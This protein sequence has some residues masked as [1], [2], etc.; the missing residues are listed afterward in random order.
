MRY[1]I[2]TLSTKRYSIILKAIQHKSALNEEQF[3]YQREKTQGRLLAKFVKI[4]LSFSAFQ[5]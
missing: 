5:S 1:G 4:Y 3:N 2:I